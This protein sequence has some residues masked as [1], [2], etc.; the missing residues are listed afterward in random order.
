MY[1]PLSPV[2]VVV[3]KLPEGK[4]HVFRQSQSQLLKRDLTHKCNPG[5]L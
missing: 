1:D 4:V 2:E 3:M 5:I